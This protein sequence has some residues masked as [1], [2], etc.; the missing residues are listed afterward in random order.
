MYKGK[1][2]SL[3]LP[4]YNEEEYIA[5]S[6]ED[7]KSLGLIDELLVVDNNSRDRTA[8]LAREAGATVITEKKQGFGNAIRR[9][10]A[11]AKGEW[12]FVAEPDGTFAAHDVWKFLAYGEEFDLVLGTRTAKELIWSG[13]N[14]GFFLRAGNE[15]VAKMV[16]FLF[17]GCSLTDCGCT[18]R[19]LSRRSLDVIGPRLTVGASHMLPEMAILAFQAGFKVIEIPINYR[20]RVGAS[21]IT[22]TLKGTLK[23][24]FRMI[25]IILCYRIRGWFTRNSFP[26][27]QSR[28]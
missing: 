22:G 23:T 21:K 1:T 7:F 24:G 27:P 13:A 16:E 11:Q 25:A 28:Q 17:S 10:L 6:V 15:F 3:V 8:G 26:S 4:A 5:R 18:F 20:P 19:L 14:M 12:V 9:G 2:I